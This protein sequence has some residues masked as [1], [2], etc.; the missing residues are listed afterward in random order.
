MYCVE[1][2][3]FFD[4]LGNKSNQIDIIITNDQ[5][6]QFRESSED[7]TRQFNCVEGCY[8]VISV[9]SHLGKKELFE[10]LDNLASVSTHKKI[11]MNPLITNKEELLRQIP[12]RIVFAYKGNT[13]E[14]TNEYLKEYYTT[15]KIGEHSPDMIIVNNQFYI[16]RAGVLGVHIPDGT[17]I[18]S[19]AYTIYKGSKY[20]GSTSLFQLISRMQT[21][22]VLSPHME[23]DFTAYGNAIGKAIYEKINE[24]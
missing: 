21:V 19:G 17:F 18:E 6:L 9:K 7:K 20:S 5:T 23:I 13:A 15:H 2:R 16:F 24:K 10:S 12:Q 1:R 11:I 3:F 4:S 8:A 14:T 22:S